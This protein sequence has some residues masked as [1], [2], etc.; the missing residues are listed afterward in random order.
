MPTKIKMLTLLQEK[1]G[2]AQ[3]TNRVPVP[4]PGVLFLMK[5]RARTAQT[6]I[7]RRR[8]AITVDANGN[9]NTPLPI[10]INHINPAAQSFSVVAR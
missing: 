2:Y 8:L 9:G 1:R 6:A 7:P 4:R 3:I 5:L 10:K